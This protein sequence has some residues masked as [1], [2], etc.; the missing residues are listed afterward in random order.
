M[1][2]RI[3][4]WSRLTRL[5]RIL[6]GVV[7]AIVVLFVVTVGVGGVGGQADLSRPPGFVTWL[8]DLF[9]GPPA[10]DPA[11]VTGACVPTTGVPAD[12]LLEFGDT[13]VLQVAPA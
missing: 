5:Q 6:L 2:I 9:G 10:V 4:L 12:G 1:R 7:T 8:G 13:C 11:D 3:P